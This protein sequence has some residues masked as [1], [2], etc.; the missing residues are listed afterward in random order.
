MCGV[1]RGN[2]ASMRWNHPAWQHQGCGEGTGQEGRQ[3]QT[4]VTDGEWAENHLG[5]GERFEQCDLSFAHGFATGLNPS[6]I[7]VDE[8]FANQRKHRLHITAIEGS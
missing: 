6:A 2:M 5:I 8:V 4:I 3:R 1:V 7:E